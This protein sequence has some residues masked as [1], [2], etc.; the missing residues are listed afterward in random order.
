MVQQNISTNTAIPPAPVL[1]FSPVVLDVPGRPVPLQIKVS[2]PATG[3]KLPIILFSHGHG[4]SNFLSSLRGYGP[5]VDF[6]AASGF[7]VLQPTH[8]NSKAL[9]LDPNGPEG[10]L[11]WKSR[12]TDMHFILDHLDQIEGAVP[13]LSGCLDKNRMVAIGHSM[14]GH[15]VSM[16]AGMTVTDPNDGQEVN[17]KEP[18]LKAA[19][20]IGGPCSPADLAPFAAEHYPIM[21]S[22]NFAGMTIPALVVAGDGDKNPMFSERDDWRADSYYLSNGPKCLLT[23][24][25]GDHMLGGISGYDA[26][27]TSDENPEQVALVQQLTLAY[28]RTALYPEDSSWE[29]AQKGLKETMD[30]KARIECK[31]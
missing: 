1:S 2:A 10:L 25:G 24:I 28:I 23:I 4:R 19:V 9:N 7:V 8:L 14:G 27:E 12:A 31:G 13:G 30:P 21:K 6:Y 15:T 3:N 16:L 26:G 29:D 17:L 5:L 18:R 20:I 22:M 11:F